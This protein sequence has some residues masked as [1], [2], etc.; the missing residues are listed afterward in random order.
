V[1]FRGLIIAAVV[2]LALSVAL[3]WSNRHPPSDDTAKASVDA[4]PKILSLD[5]SEVT[6]LAIRKK[7]DPDVQLA[8]NGTAWQITA[9]KSLAADQSTVSGILST[10]SSLN[11]DRLVDD[12]ASDLAQYGLSDPVVEVDITA[13]NKTQKLLLGEQ[14]INGNST[15]A[16]L[17]GDPRVFTIASYNKSS[18]DKSLGDLRDKRLLT[19]DFDKVTQIQLLNQ[20]PTK[21]QDITFARD[22]DSWQILKPKPYRADSSHVED[23]IRV[24]KGATFESSSSGDDPAAISSFNSGSPFVTAKVTGVSGTQELQL[25]KAKDDYYAKSS[26]VS[27][28]FKVPVSAA[29]GLDKTLDDFR[30]KKLFSFGFNDPNKIEIHDGAKS[31]FLTH[32]G[33]DWWGADGKKLDSEGVQTLLE[34]LRGLSATGFPD[35]GFSSPAIEITVVS[36]DNKRIEKVSLAKSTKS[37]IARRENE[38]AL[39]ALPASTINDLQQVAAS[40]KPATPAP[41]PSSNPAPNKK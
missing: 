8:R 28:V 29:S 1:K 15:Y 12:K 22:K 20:S 5:Q 14:T 27:G 6:A 17:A 23:L 21:K 3:Y 11:S 2:L 10:V 41:A 18:L 9:P 38:P 16:M 4:S 37:D 13:K 31:Y 33:S 39:Y 25:R 7:G 34:K 19:A 30:D 35:S 36:D 26:I 24:L 32:S 40:L